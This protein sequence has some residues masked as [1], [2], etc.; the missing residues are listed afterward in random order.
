M[1]ITCGGAGSVAVSDALKARLGTFPVAFIDGTGGGDS[2]DAGY[3][4][5]LLDGRDEVGCL[6]LAS[7]LG[8]AC[9]R[10]VGATAGA[11]TR[12]E[13]DDFLARHSL[14]VEAF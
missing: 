3:I 2:F 11:F 12:P 8:A 13:A 7:A 10:A 9:V 1:V 14:T 5:G 4:A 6:T